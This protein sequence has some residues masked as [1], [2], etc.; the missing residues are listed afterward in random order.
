MAMPAQK[1][2]VGQN[3]FVANDAVVGDMAA[4]HEKI[5]VANARFKPLIGASVNRHIFAENIV[6]ADNSACFFATKL[7]VLREFAKYGAAV[8]HVGFAH[9]K[10]AYQHRMWTDHAPRTQTDSTI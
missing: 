6:L 5:V 3:A 8:N 1:S 10:R 9:F 2:T 4:S 7:Q